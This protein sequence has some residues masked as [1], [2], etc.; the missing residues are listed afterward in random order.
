MSFEKSGR[1]LDDM[2]A[3]VQRA[4][5]S[6]QQGRL[7]RLIV[8]DEFMVSVISPL[9]RELCDQT[10]IDHTFIRVRTAKQVGR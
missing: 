10:S 9:I 4:M 8:R 3:K 5:K 7:V 2:A 1:D 6:A